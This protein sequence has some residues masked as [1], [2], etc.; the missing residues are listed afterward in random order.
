MKNLKE[1]RNLFIEIFQ[2]HYYILWTISFGSGIY[3]G[4]RIAHIIKMPQYFYYA[5]VIFMFSFLFASLCLYL[6]KEKIYRQVQV[7]IMFFPL[8]LVPVIILFLTG[9]LQSYHQ[10]S[11]Q[12]AMQN[13]GASGMPVTVC[14]RGRVTD[15]PSVLYGNTCFDMAVKQ[16]QYIQSSTGERS[17][18]GLQDF[19]VTVRLEGFNEMNILRDDFLEIRGRIY[20]SGDRIFIKS[21]NGDVNFLE[22]SRPYEVLWQLRQ[23]IYRC[24]KLTFERYLE[25]GDAHLAE[26]LV[27]GN[28]NRISD[29]LYDTF[30]KSGTAHLI[31]IS[32]MHISFLALIIYMFAGNRSKKT[33]VAVLIIIIL[34]LYNF[35]LGSKASVQR[36]TI[37][38]VSAVVAEN[39]HRENTAPRILCI[40]FIILLVINPGF[41]DDAGF[42]LSF[43]AMS[44]IVFIYPVFR[45]ISGLFKITKKMAD[46]YFAGTLMATISIHIA[47]GPV[48]LYYFGSLPLISPLS[49]VFI[50]PFFYPLIFMLFLS[51]FLSIIW[52]PA[53]GAVLRGTPVLFDIVTK[54]AE[55]FSGPWVPAIE[56]ADLS[57]VRL[58][59]YYLLLFSGALA[60][61]FLIDK[62]FDFYR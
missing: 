39:W 30:K 6:K 59:I 58:F 17:T 37:W 49:N 7:K 9:F 61:E 1:H 8:I 23:N 12:D 29:Y 15:H 35:I 14:A 18:K 40:S 44:G 20:N 42:W 41:S 52:P 36:A 32:G 45:K 50:L 16:L 55:F 24:V 2:K 11:S 34:L 54:V 46:N 13:I 33:A 10:G 62:K 21:W 47:C 60:A 27:L 43:S 19:T 22:R 48:M 57:T 26:A 3:A 38:A 4:N 51:A 28:R 5:A 25:Y 53:G 56:K 31:A